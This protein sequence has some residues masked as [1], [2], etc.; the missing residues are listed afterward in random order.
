[1]IK[2]T[3]P[4]LGIMFST[5]VL[6]LVSITAHA[7][8]STEQKLKRLEMEMQE[9]REQL[10]ATADKLETSPSAVYSG[11]SASMIQN[12]THISGYGELHYNNLKSDDGSKV[13]QEVDFHRFVLEFGH[14][15]NETTR[16]FSEMELEHAIAGDAKVG[17]IELEQAYIQ[18][19]FNDNISGNAG[20]MLVP[21]GLI[22]ETHEPTSFYG[23]ERNLVEKNIIPATWWVAGT[24]LSAKTSNGFSYDLMLHEGLKIADDGKFN[25]RSGR[26]KSGKANASDLA[27]TGRVKYTGM[28][29]IELG[30]TAQYQSDYMQGAA[31][32]GA[33]N[34]V[35]THIALNKGPLSV[36]ALYA[37]W[38]LAGDAAAAADKDKQKGAYI[39]TAYKITPKTG[40]FARY[41]IWDNGGIGDTEFNQT[42]IGVN[43]W[44]NKSV[45]LK[46]DYQSQSAGDAIAANK[47]SD[48]FNLGIGYQF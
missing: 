29:G 9:L 46:A 47:T 17:E 42:D 1:M 20:I 39:E 24:G 18:H 36:K 19:D 11:H 5:A 40:I 25:I 2:K 8:E 38:D 34:L 14:E 15:F 13:K 44:L 10:N 22:N 35:E 32:G 41:S 3:M 30:L 16:F 4:C 6:M 33:A 27:L 12:K 45:V 48:G 26:Q 21:V 37:Q 43:Y 7:T 31:N 28:A 23:V